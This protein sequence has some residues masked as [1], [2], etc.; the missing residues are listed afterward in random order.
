MAYIMFI[1]HTQVGETALAWAS[2][3]GH[4]DVVKVLL[5][6][7]ANIEA[8]DNVSWCDIMYSIDV[9]YYYMAWCAVLYCVGVI[10]KDVDCILSI[11]VLT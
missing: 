1:H 3:N 10:F 9:W 6:K 8:A 5:D 7:D 4:A 11:L 2:C